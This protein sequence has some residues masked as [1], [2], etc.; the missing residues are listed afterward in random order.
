MQKLF[1]LN[2]LVMSSE[3]IRAKEW[4][5][6]LQLKC[7]LQKSLSEF[8]DI[9]THQKSIRKEKLKETNPKIAQ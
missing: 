5:K 4:E 2:D 7:K 8:R 3:E 1:N 9:L 6:E